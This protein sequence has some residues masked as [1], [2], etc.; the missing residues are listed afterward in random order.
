MTGL[1]YK[2]WEITDII[3]V[4]SNIT[5]FVFISE[6]RDAQLW[7]GQFRAVHWWWL[8]GEPEL[9]H[10]GLHK[11]DDELPGGRSE[12]LLPR[13]AHGAAGEPA[14]DH[15]GGRAARGLQRPLWAG[16][17]EEIVHPAER[18]LPPRHRSAGGGAK[19][20]GGSGQ[21]GQTAAGPKEEHQDSSDQSRKYHIFGLRLTGT[22]WLVWKNTCERLQERIEAKNCSSTVPVIFQW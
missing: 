18:H 12:A 17:W 21:A 16:P 7:N 22:S 3:T 14:R 20:W 10:C 15:P 5:V 13:A 8:L 6:G 19:V 11:A 9:H 4:I 2:L 1:M